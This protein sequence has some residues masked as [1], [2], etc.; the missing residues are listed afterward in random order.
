MKQV[1]AGKGSAAVDQYF[2]SNPLVKEKEQQV[3]FIKTQIEAVFNV[4]GKPLG[5][6]LVAQETLAPSLRRFVYIS[7]HEY[8]ALTWEFFV[9]KPRDS[10]IASNINFDDDFSHARTRK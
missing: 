10:W 9:Y 8:H 5:Y 2:A 1:I 6:E 7:K 3:L 4:F